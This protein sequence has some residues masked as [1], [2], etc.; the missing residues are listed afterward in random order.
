MTDFAHQ[1][2]ARVLRSEPPEAIKALDPD[3][4]AKLVQLIDASLDEHQAL[5]RR[6]ERDL[7][8]QVPLPFRGAVK[9]LLR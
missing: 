3:D 2:L 9:K 6:S 5:V 7:L 8:T 4:A 1:Q